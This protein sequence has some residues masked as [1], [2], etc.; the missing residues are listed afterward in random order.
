MTFSSG[1]L[2]I[3]VHAALVWCAIAAL[4]LTALLVKDILRG[5]SW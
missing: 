4:A 3:L 5:E 1:F 2:D